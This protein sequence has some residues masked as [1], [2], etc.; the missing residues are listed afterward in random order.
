MEYIMTLPDERY[1]ALINAKIFLLKL[2]NPKDTPKV[3]SIIR[4]QARSVLK[5]YPSNYEMEKISEALPDIFSSE[6]FWKSQ[7][8]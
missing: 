5:H 8:K 2:C 1:R 4:Q 3:P 7:Q 6:P